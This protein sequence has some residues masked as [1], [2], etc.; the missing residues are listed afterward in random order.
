M[1]NNK[2]QEI[3]VYA[4]IA[5]IIV[6]LFFIG[7]ELTGSVVSENGTGVLNVTVSSLVS[8]NFTTASLDFGSGG[9]D[10]GEDG[11]TLNSEGSVLLGTWSAT[12]GELVLENI[13][14]V[15]VSLTLATNETVDNFIGGTSPT[16]KAKTSDSSGNT[17]ACSGATEVF[18][19]SYAEINQT[20]Q[21]A[22]SIFAYDT[23]MNEIDINIE[24]YIPNDAAGTKAIEITAVGSS[25]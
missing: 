2:V 24:L 5:V 22:C 11:A 1:K 20:T 8:L 9:V 13:G 21:T 16:I 17:G 18:D 15:N 19:G 4:S 25:I 7:T 3:L 6:S 10:D 23:S 14:N 12:S